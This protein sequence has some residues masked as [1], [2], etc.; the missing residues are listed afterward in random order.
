MG[1]APHLRPE[2]DA[3]LPF[4]RALYATT[5][6]D[7][8]ALLPWSA[9]QKSAFVAMQFDAQHRHYRAQFP[10]ASFEVVELA[11]TPIGRLYVDRRRD[12][13]RLVDVALLPEH[14][15]HGLGSALLEA[16]VAEADAAGLP[17]TLH[18]EPRNPA[19]RLYARLGFAVVG[20]AEGTVYQRM[21][22]EPAT[23]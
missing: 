10:D 5:R 3:D 1:T 8:L 14:R 6:E 22:R 18:V 20:H 19:A 15:G 12:E 23:G 17:V 16:I 4:L 13:V 11:G 7:E 9:E 2:T 21:R